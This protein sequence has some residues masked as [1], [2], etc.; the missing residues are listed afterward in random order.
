VGGPGYPYYCRSPGP[1][2]SPI[3]SC[4]SIIPL[5]LVIPIRA[6][7]NRIVADVGGAGGFA[8]FCGPKAYIWLGIF[9]RGYP[10]TVDQV[11]GYIRYVITL[12]L[13]KSCE[14]L[15]RR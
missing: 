12:C 4:Y 8:Y 2:S 3:Y 7:D 14:A 5:L 6:V 10:S 9:T 1:F 15:V 11:V 13:G